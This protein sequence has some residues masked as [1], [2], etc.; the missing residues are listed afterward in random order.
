MIRLLL[1]LAVILAPASAHAG[2]S[3]VFRYASE[4][5]TCKQARNIV[6]EKGAVLLF[7]GADFSL[8]DRVVHHG[9]FC[10]HGEGTRPARAPTRDQD[11]CYVGWACEAFSGGGD[12]G[13]ASQ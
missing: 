8:Y 5:M 13:G 7:W 4:S 6:A 10:Q 2:G 1:A 11:D 9:G 3:S 12:G